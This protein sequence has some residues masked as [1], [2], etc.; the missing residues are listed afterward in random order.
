MSLAPQLSESLIGKQQALLRKLLQEFRNGNVENALRHA[1]P[2]GGEPGRGGGFASD[3]RLPLHDLFYSLSNLF[4]GSG[5]GGGTIWLTPDST[6][7]ELAREYNKQAELALKNGD[8]RRAAFIYAKLLNN[9]G[10]AARALSQGGLHRDAAILYEKKLLDRRGAAREWE[11]A[12][13]IDRAIEI[14]RQLGENVLAGDLLQKVGEVDLAL[15]EYRIAAGKLVDSQRHFQAGS[16][17]I[18]KARRLDL[19]LEIFAAGWEKRPKGQHFDCFQALFRHFC[20]SGNLPAFHRLRLEAE[21]DVDLWNL[22]TASTF[23]NLTRELSRHPHLA[24]DGDDLRDG[25]MVQIAR[26]LRTEM[27][28]TQGK[29]PVG[30]VAA[31][32]PA[33]KGWGTPAIQDAQFAAKHPT[34]TSRTWDRLEPKRFTVS[35]HRVTAWWQDLQSGVLYFGNARGQLLC[36][37]PRTENV[38]EITAIDG[39]IL[40]ITG[41][42]YGQ[43]LV[44]LSAPRRSNLRLSI[45]SRERGYRQI[46]ERVFDRLPSHALLLPL[47]ANDE[48][49]HVAVT[50]CHSLIL[51]SLENRGNHSTQLMD[52]VM[53]GVPGKGTLI[54][55]GLKNWL[56]WEGRSRTWIL[57]LP[58]D[59]TGAPFSFSN[60]EAWGSKFMLE[61]PPLLATSTAPDRFELQGLTEK[62]ALRIVQLDFSDGTE[63]VAPDTW[64]GEGGVAFIYASPY[65]TYLL[66]ENHLTQ[67]HPVQGVVK[68]QTVRLENPVGGI[69]T[70]GGRAVFVLQEAGDMVRFDLV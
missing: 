52:S 50:D 59:P 6:F 13:N 9:F 20:E 38:T 56:Y 51:Q 70:D 7:L 60:A 61:G 47:V 18:D 10:A 5:A 68:T 64:F 4:T 8:Y 69:A 34:A 11:A 35:S 66:G 27:Q 23:F 14:Y 65:R 25:I 55:H 45:A 16:L 30:K 29:N 46:E 63:D 15:K 26:R 53:E 57:P 49:R 33:A 12:G 48:Q 21:R 2:I 43:S 40:A 41:T 22:E 44:S 36:F 17:L 31:L 28:H 54:T 19:A 3:A 1:L 62:G 24:N 39:S 37:D 32:M 42:R 67:I 58:F